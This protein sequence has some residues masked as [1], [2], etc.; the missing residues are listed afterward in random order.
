[1][2]LGYACVNTQVKDKEQSVLRAREL[3]LTRA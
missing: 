3:L 1:V 2:R